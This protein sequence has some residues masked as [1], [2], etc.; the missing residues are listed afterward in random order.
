LNSTGEISGLRATKA[1]IVKDMVVLITAEELKGLV[2]VLD[3][4]YFSVVMEVN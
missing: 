2:A 1:A 3:R 4:R